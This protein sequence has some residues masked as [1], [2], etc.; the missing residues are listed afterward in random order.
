MTVGEKQ[1]MPIPGYDK[2][3]SRQALGRP[4][5]VETGR[6]PRLDPDLLSGKKSFIHCSLWSLALPPGRLFHVH[7]SP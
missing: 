2:H 6:V 3:P 4:P 7:Y 5:S 1:W